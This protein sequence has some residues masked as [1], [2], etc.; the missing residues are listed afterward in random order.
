MFLKCEA[1]LQLPERARLEHPPHPP[2]PKNMEKGPP[3]KKRSIHSLCG[4]SDRRLWFDLQSGAR[5]LTNVSV[6]QVKATGERQHVVVLAEGM[7]SEVSATIV[8]GSTDCCLAA[9]S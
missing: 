8:F 4:L 1:L 9:S 7:L 3:P 6:A 5:S 2:P